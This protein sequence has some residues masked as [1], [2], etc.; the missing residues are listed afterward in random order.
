MRRK[1]VVGNWKMHG[2]KAQLGEVSAIAGAAAAHPGVDVA[3]CVPFTL[4]EA[5]A[6]AAGAMPVGAQDVDEFVAAENVR[7]RHD[8]GRSGAVPV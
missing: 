5:A 4:I 1:W 2:L 8:H 7:R 6:T 3:L